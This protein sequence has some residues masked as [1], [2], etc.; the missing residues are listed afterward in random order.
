ME[1]YFVIIE[2]LLHVQRLF[3]CQIVS[4]LWQKNFGLFRLVWVMPRRL[5]D[6]L[7]CWKGHFESELSRLLWK[8]IT[9]LFSIV[10][11]ASKKL[12]KFRIQQ[13]GNG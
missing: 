11:L 5:A 1:E 7:A 10:D 3:H 12:F 13:K 8:M 6:L 2:L 4:T 9:D